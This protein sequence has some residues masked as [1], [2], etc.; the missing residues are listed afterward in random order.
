MDNIIP[1]INWQDEKIF[2]VLLAAFIAFIAWLAKSFVEKP[3]DNSRETF[4][5]FAEKRIHIL[6]V[7]KTHLVFISLFPQD[8]K[9]KSKLQEILLKDGSTGF[10]SKESLNNVIEIS[11]SKKVNEK[12]LLSTIASLDYELALQ[13]EKIKN[14][15]SF[16]IRYS[17]NSP[18]KKILGYVFMM[19]KSVLW[20]TSA[21]FLLF[22]LIKF[23]LNLSIIWITIVI[24]ITLALIWLIEKYFL[25]KL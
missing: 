14:D 21:V 18:Y 15:Y 12:K 23:I 3:F 13:I 24:A 4:F 6:S 16:Y 9:A 20:V 17:G 19:I 8:E 10:L 2:T 22:I 25:H 5:N 1:D 7:I 11:I